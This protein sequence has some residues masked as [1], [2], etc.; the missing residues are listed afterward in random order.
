MHIV[1]MVLGAVA[2][3]AFWWYR[4]KMAN[5]ALSDA[6]DAVTT[7]RGNF[8]RRKLR[9]KAEESPVAAIDDPVL[10]AA[11]ILQSVASNEAPVS[12]KV[13][14][15][16]HEFISGLTTPQN[17]E[18]ALIYA[19]WAVSRVV[20]TPMVIDRVAPLLNARLNDAEK[21]EL[22]SM[23]RAVE[24]CQSSWQTPHSE[25]VTRLRRKLNCVPA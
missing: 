23:V 2:G 15:L 1:F 5:D 9:Q 17:T 24:K 13:N 19:R 4:L 16:I 21:E 12:K 22:I 10:A 14:D 11:T 20:E 3:A 8:R 25:A 18:E 7:L 6:Y